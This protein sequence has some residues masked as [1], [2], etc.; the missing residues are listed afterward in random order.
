MGIHKPTTGSIYFKGKNINDVMSFERVQQGI[1]IKFQITSV[2][3]NL[4]VRQNLHIPLRSKRNKGKNINSKIDDLLIQIGLDKIGDPL[5]GSLSHGQQQWLEIA[6][7]LGT[8][9]ELLLL[10]EPTAGM[11]PDE[12]FQTADIIKRINQKS[13]VTIIVIEHDMEFVKYID[14]KISVLHQGKLF[15]EGSLEEVQSHD[16]I[17]KIYL[18]T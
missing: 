2:Y 9:P 16:K 1:S 5:V 11:T 15:F 18:G 3:P 10:D 4:T 13:E 14:E 8:Y 6:M 7:A 12:T 17:K